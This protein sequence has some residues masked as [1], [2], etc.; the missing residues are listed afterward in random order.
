MEVVDGLKPGDE[1]TTGPYK[2]LSKLTDGERV[3]G[4]PAKDSIP[5]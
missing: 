3:T 2:T 1:V 5:D 4:K